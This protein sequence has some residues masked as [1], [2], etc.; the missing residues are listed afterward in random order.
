M[1]NTNKVITPYKFYTILVDNGCESVL[2]KRQ[3]SNKIRYI[4]GRVGGEIISHI[5]S[6]FN[7]TNKE[8]LERKYY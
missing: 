8:N 2:H 3:G 5:T 1:V 7:I 4:G 6:Y